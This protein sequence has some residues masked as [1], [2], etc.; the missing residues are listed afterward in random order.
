MSRRK[1]LQK[2]LATALGVSPASIT[3]LKA[4]GMPVHSVEAARR[5]RDMNLDLSRTKW[6]DTTDEP[7]VIQSGQVQADDLRGLVAHIEGLALQAVEKFSEVAPYLRAAMRALPPAYRD[8]IRLPL[9]VWDKLLADFNQAMAM[10]DA[11]EGVLP[12]GNDGET[13]TDD[14][15][16]FMGR[17]WYAVAIGDIRANNNPTTNCTTPPIGEPQHECG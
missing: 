15:A 10:F 3:K 17:F 12:D 13:M 5:W 2:E 14:D 9:E 8:G 7:K 11:A 4:R 1:L 6:P 16:D